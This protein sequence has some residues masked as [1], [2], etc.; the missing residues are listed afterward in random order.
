MHLLILPDRPL[1]ADVNSYKLPLSMNFWSMIA[2][3]TMLVMVA[4]AQAPAPSRAALVLPIPG[5]PLSVETVHEW[6][7]RNLDGTSTSGNEK[8][9]EYRDAAGKLRSEWEVRDA[10]GGPVS[11]ILLAD[12]AEGS[13][14]VLE[15]SA[16]I[17]HRLQAPKTGPR[18]FVS[19]S[20]GPTGLMTVPGKKT[21]KTEN[22]GTRNIEGVEF[23]GARTTTT[24]DEQPSLVAVDENW[25][26]KEL[27]LIGLVKHSGPDGEMTSRIQNLDR[28]VPDPALFVIPA[29]YRIRDMQP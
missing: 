2:A 27:G 19:I 23:E 25:R 26:S 21:Q 4:S 17:A 24:S 22:L 15:T 3:T 5:A 7:M 9:T 8:T 6:V 11:M 1:F 16:K 20:S 18:G 29:D 14:V 13:I 10:F 28:T 12:S